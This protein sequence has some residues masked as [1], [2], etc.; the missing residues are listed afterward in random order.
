LLFRFRYVGSPY[1]TSLSEADQQKYLYWMNVEKD[2][3]D[4][5]YKWKEK[6]RLPI[7]FGRKYYK[8]TSL[9]D[10]RMKSINKGDRIVFT[11]QPKQLENGTELAKDLRK[12]GIEVDIRAID[13]V[14]RPQH[15]SMRGDI[16]SSDSTYLSEASDTELSTI[17]ISEPILPD[18]SF[19]QND[20]LTLFKSFLFDLDWNEF[21]TTHQLIVRNNSSV[22]TSFIPAPGSGI[23]F[24]NDQSVNLQS[25]PVVS[26]GIELIESFLSN[27]KKEALTS[28]LAAS[29]ITGERKDLTLHSLT[30][31]NFGPYSGSKL[32][33]PLSKRGLVLIRGQLSDGTGADSNGSGKTTLVMSILWGLTGNMDT[34]LIT[35]SRLPEVINDATS[36][37]FDVMSDSAAA[38]TSSPASS[39]KHAEVTIRGEINQKPFEV[40]RRKHAK[41]QELLFVY[42]NEDIT[43]QSIKDTQNKIN[44]ILGVG[45]GLLQRCYFFGQHSHTSQSLLGLSDTKLKDELSALINAEIWKYLSQEIRLNEKVLKSNINDMNITNN[46]KTQDIIQLNQS[47][48]TTKGL[49]D[50]ENSKLSL[51]IREK[52]QVENAATML[53]VTEGD[54]STSS[55]NI[56]L[57]LQILE[58]D[59]II[60]QSENERNALQKS[61]LQPLRSEL[62]LILQRITRQST[63]SSLSSFS[64]N[65]SF[66]T[67]PASSS[68]SSSSSYDQK[69]KDLEKVKSD[70]SYQLANKQNYEQT[71]NQLQ[72]KGN[73]EN[74]QLKEFE[75]SISLMIE[76]SPE[77]TDFFQKKHKKKD[78]IPEEIKQLS[79]EYEQE[80]SMIGSLNEQIKT[81]TTSLHHLTFFHQIHKST[82][83]S[84]DVSF[85]SLNDYPDSSSTSVTDMSDPAASPVSTDACPTCG[86]DMIGIN[87]KE[88]EIKLRSSYTSLMKQLSYHQKNQKSIKYLINQ[89]SLLFQRIN[90]YE[91]KEKKL[92]DYSTEIT[93]YQTRIK[94]TEQAIT[95]SLQP[96]ILQL[97]NDLEEERQ[98]LQIQSTQITE[99]LLT[100]EK[101]LTN[102]NEQII[103]KQHQRILLQQQLDL[104]TNILKE[105][106]LQIDL[107]KNKILLYNN[108][109]YEKEYS[110][111]TLQKEINE[112]NQKEKDILSQLAIYDS[113][114]LLFSSRGIQQYIF[115]SFLTSLELI[116][117]YYLSYLS[118][119]GIQLSLL[120]PSDASSSM[121]R[122]MKVVRIR[123]LYD[124]TWKE[125]QLSQLS[126]GQWRRVSLALDFAFTQ[127]VK[128]RSLLRCNVL[129]LDEILTHLD[130]KGRESV[131]SLLKAMTSKS[132]DALQEKEGQDEE[133]KATP[134]FNDSFETILVILQDLA[135]RE[136]EESFDHMDVV[137]KEGDLSKIDIDG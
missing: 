57:D 67:P 74:L 89:Y 3:S 39:K 43:A 94:E 121:D 137:V 38:A 92:S 136:L 101:Q 115:Q 6:E 122:I 42:N 99:Q 55:R 61:S 32:T 85:S 2:P 109:L 90:E 73:N 22:S 103:L 62:D 46:L 130:A 60:Q 16:S 100:I 113:L 35:D 56:P 111:N 71:L 1:Q 25:N 84:K 126:G 83:V 82:S 23:G 133:K 93:V 33:Y 19:D 66:S 123:S 125:R 13:L 135:A 127:L 12:K 88:R 20:P 105:K 68:S 114:L 108:T 44:E 18:Y 134:I 98:Q 54:A 45:T 21:E 17:E 77:I 70:L 30:L 119:N 65:P 104:Q 63:S 131:G 102:L 86:Q 120:L 8:M 112:N 91:E 59:K 96:R 78:D 24:E 116:A 36:T 49:I 107:L 132:L 10:E 50:N 124:G 26:K 75:N 31:S 4:L 52:E 69:R 87:P 5:G 117:N 110:I 15:L 79:T 40:I 129:V 27:S 9:E 29:S 47:I 53:S 11:L 28:S 37:S 41:K 72:K 51:L 58:I 95:S 128:Q 80:L 34:R 7:N 106:Q 118:D 81:I 64:R 97:E 76:E 48:L 14:K